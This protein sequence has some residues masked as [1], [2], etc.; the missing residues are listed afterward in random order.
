MV[1][2]Y[3]ISDSTCPYHNL[4]LEQLLFEHCGAE[5]IILY[6]WQNEN[7]IVIGKNQEPYCE[8][9]VDEFLKDKGRLARRRSGGGAVFHDLGNLNF[10]VICCNSLAGQADHRDI[11]I[12]SF[13]RLGVDAKYNG[14][15]DIM[16]NDR[17]FSGNA[18]FSDGKILCQHGTVLI[19]SDIGKMTRYLTPDEKKLRRNAVKSVSARVTNL[20][21]LY[22]QISVE[23]AREAM[24]AYTGAV[25]LE[26][27]ISR[28]RFSAL[29]EHYSSNGWIYGGVL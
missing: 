20:S 27:D 26:A 5:T 12:G 8:C 19:S 17:K 16:C 15:N 7:T 4:A 18:S 14:K 3:L 2:K 28:D 23:S 6:L 24:I 25:K 10:S 9:R 29:M 11:I 1:F 13:R 21:E 22:P